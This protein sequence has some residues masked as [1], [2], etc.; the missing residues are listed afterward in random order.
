[1]ERKHYQV[2]ISAEV[3][4]VTSRWCA[5]LPTCGAYDACPAERQARP[6]QAGPGQARLGQARSHH[7]IPG[8]TS[9]DPVPTRAG[10]TD[11]WRQGRNLHT[12][13]HLPTYLTAH[14]IHHTTQISMPLK[15]P[16]TISTTS[17]TLLYCTHAVS[18]PQMF[19]R[20]ALHRLAGTPRDVTA[21]TNRDPSL[22]NE[23][24]VKPCE[25]AA[26]PYMW[27]GNPS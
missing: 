16:S 7:A 4:T 15:Y 26:Q 23:G 8:R 20:T 2:H 17:H 14:A 27:R 21:P 3:I 18:Q 12:P 6:S 25:S 22:H 9:R 24:D 13:P 11:R 19:A 1:M 5:S 10:N